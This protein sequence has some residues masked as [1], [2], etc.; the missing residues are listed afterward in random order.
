M[1]VVVVVMMMI[2]VAN[3]ALQAACDEVNRGFMSRVYK[4]K[5]YQALSLLATPYVLPFEIAFTLVRKYV[6]NSILLYCV[7]SGFI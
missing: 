7:P 5:T 4:T 2:V 3:A 1:V 6:F